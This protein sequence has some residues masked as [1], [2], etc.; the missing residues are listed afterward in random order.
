[1]MMSEF[2]LDSMPNLQT[3]REKAQWMEGRASRLFVL[4][5]VNKVYAEIEMIGE[6][7]KRASVGF[8]QLF[9]LQKMMGLQLETLVRMLNDAVPEFRKKFEGEYKR[10]ILFSQFIESFNKEGLNS[11]KPFREKIDIVRAW[12]NDSKNVK[13]TGLYFGLSD[14]VLNNISEF[15]EEE[16]ATFEDEFEIPDLASEFSKKKLEAATSDNKVP[17]GVVH[18]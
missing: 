5:E 1:M 15:T 7:L 18:A 11:E 4:T 13:V 12:N 2:A 8:S 6:E 9:T 3:E 14:Y 10:T 17:E 16:V